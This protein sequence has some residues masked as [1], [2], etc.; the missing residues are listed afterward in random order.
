MEP[1]AT[2]VQVQQEPFAADAMYCRYPRQDAAQDGIVEFNM[3]TGKLS[4]GYNPEIGNAIPMDVY[5]GRVI[6]WYCA[7]VQG[8]NIADMLAEIAPHAQ[9]M[10]D[11]SH[12]RADEAM[13]VHGYADEAITEIVDRYSEIAPVVE[14][15]AADW[16]GY[17]SPDVVDIARSGGAEAVEAW[18]DAQYE[19]DG[20]E[21]APFLY[22]RE[23]FID[24]VLQLAMPE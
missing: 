23:A 7:P 4:V 1:T 14:Y 13:A 3:Q 17:E 9:A 19:Q 20:S 6:R 22:G 21:R 5:D 12:G 18:L 16:Y 24:W 15:A 11:A 8:D 2:Q 10:L